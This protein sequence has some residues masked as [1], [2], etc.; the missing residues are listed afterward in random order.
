MNDMDA[1]ITKA[2]E[3]DKL[4]TSRL[5]SMVESEDPRSH[6]VLEQLYPHAGNAFY[7]GVTGSPG[8]GKSTLVDKLVGKFCD[9][10][11]AVAV[12][13]V[14]PCSPFTGGALLGD[15]VRMNYRRKARNCFFRSMSAGKV[16]GGLAQ[17]TKEASWI[18]DACGR[19]V[20]I[21]ETV[22]VGQ[23]ELDIMMASDTVVVALTPESGDSIQIMKAGLFEIADIFA[24]NKSDRPGAD[25][26][27]FSID[28]MLDRKEQVTGKMAW[29]PCVCKTSADRNHGISELY[30]SICFHQAHLRES[31][32]FK[33][34][35]A[36]QYK[37]ELL[38][39]IEA[40]IK[41]MTMGGIMDNPLLQ[42]F[43]EYM[44]GQK[45]YPRSAARTIAKQLLP[46]EWLNSDKRPELADII[47]HE[48]MAR[49]KRTV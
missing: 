3:G 9:N 7:I 25:D 19:D 14:D 35:R 15:R 8:A 12:I 49:I 45:R 20:I 30:E 10:D 39:G 29:R 33:D 1:V 5:I 37:A 21:I 22:G 44:R 17:K 42:E 2:L 24:V 16:L 34:R 4:S 11:F 41:E 48:T 43:S 13:A 38:E 6:V 31:S 47:N 28:N 32:G 26:I 18:L 23:S 36:L 40:E 46:K 27:K